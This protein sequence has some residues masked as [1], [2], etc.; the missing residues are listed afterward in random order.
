MTD[1]PYRS[2]RR[3]LLPQKSRLEW[4]LRFNNQVPQDSTH[5]PVEETRYEL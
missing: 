4:E 5:D 2:G 3:K 1:V